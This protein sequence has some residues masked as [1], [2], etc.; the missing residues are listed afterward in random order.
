MTAT[1]VWV[2]FFGGPWDGDMREVESD[3]AG[4]PQRFGVGWVG[5]TL[6]F[7]EPA[8]VVIEGIVRMRWRFASVKWPRDK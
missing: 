7:Y 3:E 1:S 4:N 8:E 2:E 5:G 6:G